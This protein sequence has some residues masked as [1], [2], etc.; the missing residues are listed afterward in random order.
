VPARRAPGAF[1]GQAQ[2]AGE[3]EARERAGV[4]LPFG[5]QQSERDRK[6]E[7]PGFLRQLRR[8][9]VDRDALVVWKRETALLQGGAHP[10]ARLL[11]LGLGQ[12]DQREAR[13]PVDQLDLDPDFW[14]RPARRASG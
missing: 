13:Q 12:A 11:D 9:Q 5:R 8:G 6:V 3:F 10:F 7:A 4:Q 2:L 14:E 1:A